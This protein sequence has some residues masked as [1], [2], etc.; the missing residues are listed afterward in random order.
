M[1]IIEKILLPFIIKDLIDVICAYLTP[2]NQHILGTK[3][4]RF[5]MTEI[6]EHDPHLMVYCIKK[7]YLY[8]KDFLF[9]LN[10]RCGNLHNLQWLLNNHFPFDEWTFAWAARNDNLDNLKWL[11]ANH[12]P[13][14]KKTFAFACETGNI[15]ILKWLLDNHFPF[16][17]WTFAYA[18]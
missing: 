5:D 9:K 12:F 8:I 18:A 11:L 15:N 17:E 3:R 13:F 6:I 4:M 1:S 7:K 14:D 16:D 10:A 2:S